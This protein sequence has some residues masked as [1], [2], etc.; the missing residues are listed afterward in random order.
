MVILDDFA[1]IAVHQ[2]RDNAPG[3]YAWCLPCHVRTPD[4]ATF[5]HGS[6]DLVALIG[7]VNEHL[8]SEQHRQL[9]AVIGEHHGSTYA[10]CP[11]SGGRSVTGTCP[12][13]HVI[14]K[15]VSR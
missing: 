2:D 6:T 10:R 7:A 12:E 13:G 14:S 5:G 11:W 1:G 9:P 8:A 15:V 3:V 4:E